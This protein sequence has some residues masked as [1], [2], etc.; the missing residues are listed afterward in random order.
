[1]DNVLEREILAKAMGWKQHP[2]GWWSSPRIEGCASHGIDADKIPDP[3]TDANDDVAVLKWMRETFLHGQGESDQW[4][5]YE[6]GDYARHAI[7]VIN[8]GN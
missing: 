7:G 4:W 3:Y 8:N 6:T 5:D 1:M 2:D